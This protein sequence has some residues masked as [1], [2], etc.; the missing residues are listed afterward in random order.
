M[1]R[2]DERDDKI[3]TSWSTGMTSPFS[4]RPTVGNHPSE[5]T[6]SNR[7]TTPTETQRESN[8]RQNC[9]RDSA[10]FCMLLTS[11]RRVGVSGQV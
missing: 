10:R 2:L 4:G 6:S 5:I 8:V 11:S 7:A 9:M 1:T 3:T